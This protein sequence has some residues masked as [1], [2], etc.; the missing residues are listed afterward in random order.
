[1]QKIIVSAC[2]GIGGGI[3]IAFS[4][5]WFGAVALQVEYL[6]SPLANYILLALVC[7][8]VIAAFIS[9]LWSAKTVYAG[10]AWS[11]AKVIFPIFLIGILSASILIHLNSTFRSSSTHPLLESPT[12]QGH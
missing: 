9:G 3:A 6:P 10:N 2:S 7:L 11:A 5:L 8:A 4:V 1:M 12:N